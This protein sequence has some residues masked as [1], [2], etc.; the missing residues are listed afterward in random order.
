MDGQ[1][2]KVVAIDC[3]DKGIDI[4]YV[5]GDIEEKLPEVWRDMGFIKIG[6]EDFCEFD[7]LPSIYDTEEDEDSNIIQHLQIHATEEVI[8]EAEEEGILS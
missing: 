2:F 4:Q 6:K 8:Q 7:S 5:N 1:H 3:H